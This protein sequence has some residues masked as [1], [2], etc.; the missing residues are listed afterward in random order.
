MDV[1]AERPPVG[2]ALISLSGSAGQVDT[3][4]LLDRLSS[5]CR[6][7]DGIVDA[8]E[9]PVITSPLFGVLQAVAARML[10]DGGGRLVVV[11]PEG[12]LRRMREMRAGRD[13]A[14]S[15][16]LDGARWELQRAPSR[17]QRR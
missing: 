16:T 11:C 4:A 10:R 3:A 7:G 8:R 1:H 17:F 12:D 2:P 5:A 15:A 6:G 14:L 9:V 13:F